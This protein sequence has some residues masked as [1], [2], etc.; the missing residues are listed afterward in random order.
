MTRK[1]R[2]FSP[3]FKLEAAQLVVDQGYTIRE[4]AEAMNVSKT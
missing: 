2:S 4:A 3:E 1:R